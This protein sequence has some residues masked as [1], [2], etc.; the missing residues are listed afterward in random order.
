MELTMLG[1]GSALVT[2]CF[3]TCYVFEEN[4]QYFL[5]DAAEAMKYSNAS[6]T[7]I[8]TIERFMIL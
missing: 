2:E 4:D 8:S 3:N 7:T 1:T 6:K 5:V